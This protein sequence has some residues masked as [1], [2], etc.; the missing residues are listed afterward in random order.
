MEDQGSRPMV[1][2]Q[3]TFKPAEDFLTVAGRHFATGDN[4][5]LGKREYNEGHDIVWTSLADWAGRP[6]NINRLSDIFIEFAMPPTLWLQQMLPVERTDKLIFRYRRVIYERNVANLGV[7]KTIAPVTAARVE[8]GEKH[9]KLIAQG[10]SFDYYSFQQNG[11]DRI[12]N[13]FMSQVYSNFYVSVAVGTI[14]EFRITPSAYTHPRDRYPTNAMPRT[15]QDVFRQRRAH[16][17]IINKRPLAIEFLAAEVNEMFE[18]KDQLIEGVIMTTSDY[19]FLNSADAGRIYTL[20][21]GRDAMF[22][23]SRLRDNFG[24]AIHQI[25]RLSESNHNAADEPLLRSVVARGSIGTF[26]DDT[27]SMDPEDFRSAFLDFWMVSWTSNGRD[28]YRLRDFFRSCFQFTPID[29]VPGY[30]SPDN[31]RVYTETSSDR[32]GPVVWDIAKCDEMNLPYP[33]SPNRRLLHNFCSKYDDVMRAINTR[34]DG[35]HEEYDVMVRYEPSLVEHKSSELR[36]MRHVL[37]THITETQELQKTRGLMPVTF[38]GEIN[39]CKVSARRAIHLYR[40]ARARIFAGLT[41][42]ERTTF[43]RGLQWAEEVNALA[44]GLTTDSVSQIIAKNAR[45]G[46]GLAPNKFGGLDLPD[47]HL[48][49]DELPAGYGN[50]SGMYTLANYISQFPSEAKKMHKETVDLLPRFVAVYEKVISNLQKHFSRCL[51]LDPRMCPLQHSGKNVTPEMRAKIVAWYTLF[52]PFSPGL[53]IPASFQYNDTAAGLQQISKILV[54]IPYDF[55]KGTFKVTHSPKNISDVLEM[56]SDATGF[57]VADF[58][59]LPKEDLLSKLQDVLP[60]DGYVK[61]VPYD[62]LLSIAG[63]INHSIEGKVA[64]S[65]R[66]IFDAGRKSSGAAQTRTAL[67][68]PLTSSSETYTNP[69]S[70]YKLAPAYRASSS[71][72]NVTLHR[73]RVMTVNTEANEVAPGDEKKRENY[74]TEI[75]KGFQHLLVG[76]PSVDDTPDFSPLSGTGVTFGDYLPSA[77]PFINPFWPLVPRTANVHAKI[78]AES[79]DFAKQVEMSIGNRLTSNSAPFCNGYD[80]QLPAEFPDHV[81]YAELYSAVAFSE[82]YYLAM[83]KKFVVPDTARIGGDMPDLLVSLITHPVTGN[84]FSPSKDAKLS[85]FERRWI[86]THLYDCELAVAARA[87]LL[88]EMSVP[89]LTQLYDGDIDPWLSGSILRP[90]ETQHFHSFIFNAFGRLGTTYIGNENSFMSF[91]TAAKQYDFDGELTHGTVITAQEKFFWQEDARGGSDLG[92]K[93]NDFIRNHPNLAIP[94]NIA[95]PESEKWAMDLRK[96]NGRGEDLGNWSNVAVLQ[97]KEATAEFR[98]V[99]DLDITGSWNSYGF[100]NE[101]HDYHEF[102]R[103]RDDIMF[104][105]APFVNFIHRFYR[106]NTENNPNANVP[107]EYLSFEQKARTKR[108]NT[109]CNMSS[110]LHTTRHRLSLTLEGTHAW[111]REDVNC[112]TIQTSRG[113]VGF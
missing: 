20:I 15:P 64:P 79:S 113:T 10:F 37:G 110:T 93:G 45:N 74:K 32:S 19:M 9:G 102:G 103:T 86:E 65:L 34:P 52:R 7:Q 57:D 69:I 14:T 29:E 30:Y 8:T 18:R 23:R 87:M 95:N 90:F 76:S 81:Q 82:D 94:Y 66:K 5:L 73:L 21:S 47:R 70:P 101:L 40:T 49:T 91:Q 75:T 2:V 22:N 100:V 83:R 105:G 35:N 44:V 62:S 25:P 38:G 50:I 56:L 42:D 78:Q 97:G 3:S 31:A 36:Q 1:L 43:K 92:G 46:N 51:A 88:C 112:R 106:M 108:F 71:S 107:V 61:K 89:A 55:S 12:F 27:Y 59:N 67:W 84:P 85:T 6:E 4:P 104:D 28:R 33:G 99:W 13:G 11:A 60:V 39:E 26:F 63:I 80:P 68:I 17:G 58:E 41:A 111:G 54:T 53:G 98:G 109:H 96:F 16:F 48:F 24:L 72:N 77:T